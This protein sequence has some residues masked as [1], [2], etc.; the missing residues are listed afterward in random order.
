MAQNW[1]LMSI[2]APLRA[3]GMGEVYRAND[4][5][6]LFEEFKTSNFYF[7]G[8]T[9]SPILAGLDGLNDGMLRGVKM[10]GGVLVLRRIA[11]ADVAAGET[12]AQMDPRVSDLEAVF[13]A[14]RTR[15]DVTNFLQVF[16]LAH[17]FSP[18]ART[19]Q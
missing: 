3:G 8:V 13:T 7:I 9:P 17:F 11:A 15:L 5:L 1:V 6:L 10:F 19:T 16:A 12:H 2:V 4:G 14:A 18:R